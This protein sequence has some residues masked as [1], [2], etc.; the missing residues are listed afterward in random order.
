M[1][2]GISSNVSKLIKIKLKIAS[3]GIV[4]NSKK[5]SKIIFKL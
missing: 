1:R 4:A 2:K 5:S 3:K